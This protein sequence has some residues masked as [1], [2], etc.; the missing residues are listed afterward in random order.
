[1]V[2][3]FRLKYCIQ[4]IIIYGKPTI[5][6]AKKSTQHI[7]PI[8]SLR[9]LAAVSVFLCHM[10]YMNF[11]EHQMF[12]PW[13]FFLAG[14]EA[15]ILFFVL[16]GYILSLTQQRENMPFHS[17]FIRRIFRIY[18]VYY[19]S[20]IVGVIM[21]ILIRPTPLNQY[22]H[23]FNTQ[24]STVEL[25]FTTLKDCVL[26]VTNPV[27]NING[28]IWSLVYEVLVSILILPL[29]WKLKSSRSFILLAFS[30]IFFFISRQFFHIYYHIFDQTIYFSFFF[31]LGYLIFYYKDKLKFLA[32]PWFLPFYAF[33]Y[34]SFYFSSG[35]ILFSKGTIRDILSGFGSVGFLCMAIYNTTTI[36]ILSNKIINFYGRISYSFYLLHICVMYSVVYLF[37][38]YLSMGYLI[39]LIFI[40]TTIISTITYLFIEKPFIHLGTW[41]LPTASKS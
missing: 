8:D 9:G 15:V 40:F 7:I 23:W 2:I 10:W 33:C 20:T 17:Y 11:P 1:M 21:F 12:K 5:T 27:S 41:L 19:F 16:S 30:Y 25:S 14:N 6:I 13:F 3:I 39:C 38:D 4:I 36:S 35:Y 37:H 34:A 26:L 28:A 24:F 18:P 29:F 32:N 22:T 31:Y